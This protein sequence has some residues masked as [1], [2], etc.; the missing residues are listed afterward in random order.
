MTQP[1][2]SEPHFAICINN[3]GYAVSLEVRKIYELIPDEDASHDDFV[4]VV[5]ESGE[6]YLFPASFFVPIALP[7]A[8]EHA[9][10]AAS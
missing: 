6:D 5:D 1:S 10:K 3:E 7:E 8:A 4:R 9:F 2:P